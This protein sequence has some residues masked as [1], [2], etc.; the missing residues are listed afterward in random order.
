MRTTFFMLSIVLLASACVPSRQ[1]EELKVKQADCVEARENLTNQNRTLTA[2]NEELNADLE[3]LLETMKELKDDTTYLGKRHR[4]TRDKYTELNKINDQLLEKLKQIQSQGDAENRTLLDA[5]RDTQID[6][7]RRE[8]DLRELEGMLNAKEKRLNE[9]ES[10]LKDREAR[11]KELED[12]IAEK[13]AAV[14]ALKDRIS[15]A[16]LGFKDKGLTVEQRNGKIYV[17]LEAK[18]LFPSGSTVVNSEGKK[19]LL[20]LSKVVKEEKEITILVEG[21]TDT[22]PINGGAA[23]KDNWDLS[24]LRATSVVRIMNQEG[25]VDNAMLTAAG[26]GHYIP[27][28]DNSSADG[29]AKNRRIEII[30]TPNLDRLFEIL[31]E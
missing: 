13:D 17:S 20:D 11:V 2:Q 16:L 7:Q 4:Q 9:V 27:V 19:A 1:Y 21:H 31:N 6:L 29:K 10:E 12:I 30:L 24:V 28:A 15:Q 22:D 18:L 8:D 26:R 5:L 14:R 25:G 3:N 23:M